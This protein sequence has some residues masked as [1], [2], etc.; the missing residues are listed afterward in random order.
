MPSDASLDRVS[1]ISFTCDL[2]DNIAA[3]WPSSM[4]APSSSCNKCMLSTLYADQ[5]SCSNC[6][7]YT[8]WGCSGFLFNAHK[9]EVH[10]FYLIPQNYFNGILLKMVLIWYMNQWFYCSVGSSDRCTS[11]LAWRRMHL[12]QLCLSAQFLT[13]SC[14]WKTV[15]EFLLILTHGSHLFLFFFSSQR[16]VLGR[17]A[18][19][20]R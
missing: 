19:A 8:Q 4:Q 3:P 17:G 15:A 14:A 12:V 16:I 6:F 5:I 20:Q 13:L 7:I 2:N 9:I 10:N 1:G 11:L 18:L